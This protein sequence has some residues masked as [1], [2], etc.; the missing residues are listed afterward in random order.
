MGGVD[1]N[2]LEQSSHIDSLDGIRGI[3]VAMVL[4][5]HAGLFETGWSGVD[6]FFVLSGFLIT[7]ILRR[8][9]EEPLY[10]RR[11]Y[12]KRATRI[13]PPLV[14][15]IVVAV[16][17][18]PRQS[19]IG[20]L[21]YLFSLG[22]IV[23]LTRFDIYP[24][25]HLWSLSVEE[26]YY[27]LWPFAVLWLP[28]QTLKWLLAIVI[29]ALPVSRF[30][31]TYLVPG[32][33]PNLIYYLT[34]FRIDGIA[35]GS[36]LALLLEQSHW[37]ELLGRWSACGAVLAAA[38][39]WGLR[40]YL[41]P[42]HFFP[43]GHSAVF[44]GVGYWLVA[45]AAFFVIAYARLRPDTVATRVLRNPLLVSLGVISYGLYVYSRIFLIV[46]RA[47]VPTLS[48]YQSGILDI[49]VAIPTAAVLFK[50]YE[51]PITAWGKRKAAA[52]LRD[53]R[54]ATEDSRTH[55]ESWIYNMDQQVGI[56]AR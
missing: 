40:K 17:L 34:P 3:A 26:H 6:L 36:L 32:H 12:L 15:G 38:V 23:D 30:L 31:F 50:C 48:R 41:G 55:E 10:W 56:E 22:N 42:H 13:L 33:N 7:S 51:R 18:W 47:R 29:A 9:R 14:L 28:R 2:V 52:P 39:Y 20:V 5:H 27:L 4:L 45:V 46:L 25:D 37:R 43:W 21:G 44:D 53:S 8:S 11:F 19:F 54:P 49:V 35:L 1:G 16:L 24:L